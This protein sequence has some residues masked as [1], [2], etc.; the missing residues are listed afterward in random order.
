MII[1]E[2]LELLINTNELGLEISEIEGDAILFYRYGER[3]D[4]QELYRQ[5]EKM[6][7]AF[8][9]SLAA[10]DYRKYCQCKA[11]TAAI[12]LSLKVV[13]HY[14]EFTGYNVKQFNKLIGKDIIVA[15]QLLKNDIER[16]EYW[17]IT[18]S[19]L[20]GGIPDHFADWMTW[21]NSAK[22]TETGEVAFH[23]T[24]L[25]RLRDGIAPEPMPQPELSQ[26]AKAVS[27]ARDYEADIIALF[28]AVGDFTY[29]DRW[30]EG[31]RAVEEADHFLPRLGMRCRC[32]LENGQ[33]FIYSSSYSFSP[34]HIEFSETDE[35]TGSIAYYTLERTGERTSKLT[36]DL[37]LRRNVS[38]MLFSLL[39]KRQAEAG[40]VRS[41]QRLD[42]L[43]KEIPLPG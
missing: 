22:Q 39:K 11:C 2:L 7:C 8:H 4:L 33:S 27:V 29:R 3:P 40:L 31:V 34:E 5:V 17:L 15:H 42:A 25:S 12:D 1:Q 9:R 38:G 14:G 30:R 13:T 35:G 21:N 6:F 16:H 41:L 19:L 18:D 43:V 23:Y 37:Y 20:P 32:I 24:Y 28:H 26:M 36:L 10:Y